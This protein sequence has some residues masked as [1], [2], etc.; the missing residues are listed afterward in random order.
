MIILARSCIL[1]I[2]ANIKVY[3]IHSLIKQLILVTNL[4]GEE[5]YAPLIAAATKVMK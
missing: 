4:T 5:K 2:I 3:M 1:K